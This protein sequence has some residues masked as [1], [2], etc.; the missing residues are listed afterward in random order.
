MRTLLDAKL[1]S[2]RAERAARCWDSIRYQGSGVRSP[3]RTLIPIL[4]AG[5]AQRAGGRSRAPRGDAR[6]ARPRIL[7]T[8]GQGLLRLVPEV[9]EARRAPWR[10][11]REQGWCGP[12]SASW[13]TREVL[14]DLLGSTDDQTRS[15][16]SLRAGGLIEG[17]G[18]APPRH[19]PGRERGRRARRRGARQAPAT[20][21]T[22]AGFASPWSLR[23]A[24]ARSPARAAAALDRASWPARVASA[25]GVRAWPRRRARHRCAHRVP[26]P[27]RRSRGVVSRA[28]RITGTCASP[29]RGAGQPIAS[30]TP[31][32][33]ALQ[34]LADIARH[35]ACSGTFQYDALAPS[36]QRRLDGA[37]GP[38]H[39]SA[40][41]GSPAR[42]R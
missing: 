26:P 20:D 33:R 14:L 18:E 8:E 13:T 16:R 24:R 5:A 9:I 21:R 11:S 10:S 12:R 22:H 30:R 41:A 38:G 28:P 3:P 27:P 42:L 29:E 17:A 34:G 36:A 25:M 40:Q 2:K 37:V 31:A 19:E 7:M 35:E 6:S 23:P 32:S 1:A 15:C 4:R 39:A